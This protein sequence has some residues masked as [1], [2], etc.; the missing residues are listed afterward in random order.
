MEQELFDPSIYVRPPVMSLEGGIALCRSLIDACPTS[1]P[2]S[3][4]SGAQKLGR[5]ADRAQTALA[6]RQKALGTISDEDA[7]VIDQLG[8]SSWGS[9]RGRLVSYSVL[10]VGEYPDAARAGEL[11]T[12]LFHTDGLNFLKEAYPVQW[13]T[14]DTILKRIDEEGLQPDIDRIAGKEFLENV[15]KRHQH[16]GAMVKGL[17]TRSQGENVNLSEE[18]RA[19]GSAIVSY[20]TKVCAT[21]DEDEPATIVA[22]RAALRP[23]DLFREANARRSSGGASGE[24]PVEGGASS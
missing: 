16:Y 3:V 17:L 23:L 11:V 7:R 13:T 18:I 5:A 6:L 12:I 15:R 24:S 14:A 22:A 20:A 21:V 1:M 2:K 9:L 8:D 19:L 10:P 4:K